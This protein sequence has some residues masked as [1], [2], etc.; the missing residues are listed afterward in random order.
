M[1]IFSIFHVRYFSVE[2]LVWLPPLYR[3]KASENI[4]VKLKGWT[5]CWPNL[6]NVDKMLG[7]Q[8]LNNNNNNK[9][10]WVHAKTNILNQ[11]HGLKPFLNL[12]TKKKRLYIECL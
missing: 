1:A 3:Q 10:I 2:A 6:E 8:F 4:S 5:K 12:E 7:S 9:T 11:I